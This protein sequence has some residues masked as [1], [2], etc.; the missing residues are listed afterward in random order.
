MARKLTAA[1]NAIVRNSGAIT[2]RLQ[3]GSSF[4]PAIP[5]AVLVF[6]CPESPRWYLK[7]G[8]M[9]D[10]YT[11]MRKL[12][13]HDLLAARDLFYAA[14]QWEA[15]KKVMGDKSIWRRFSELFTIPRIKRATLAASTLHVGQN[16][17]GIN[18]KSRLPFSN[19]ADRKPS[20]SIARPSSLKAGRPSSRRCTPRWASVSP[21]RICTSRWHG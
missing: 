17:C 10:A 2:W 6:F 3:I 19:V 4:I 15:E 8:R 13:R 1:A 7:K 18:S 5:L 21:P 14:V 20:H 9:V 12:R 16:L 11:S